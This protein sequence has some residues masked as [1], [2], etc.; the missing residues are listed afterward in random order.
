MAGVESLFW[1]VAGIGI[2]VR[3]LN[4]DRDNKFGEVADSLCNK[5]DIAI[6]IQRGELAGQL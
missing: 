4:E 6:P 2:Q 5:L 1:G 3:M